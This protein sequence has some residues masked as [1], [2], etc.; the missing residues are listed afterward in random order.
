MFINFDMVGPLRSFKDN[1]MYGIEYKYWIS[2]LQ[3]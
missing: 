2:E 1:L 3:I